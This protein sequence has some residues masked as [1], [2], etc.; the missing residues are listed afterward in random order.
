MNISTIIGILI[1]I[2]LIVASIFLSAVQPGVYVNGPGLLVVV[3]GT[4]AATL[5]SFPMQEL[6]RVTNIIGLI[7]RQEEYSIREDVSEIANA[8]RLRMR[9]DFARIED[10]LDRIDNPFLRTAIQLVADGTPQEEIMSMLNWRVRRLRER[11]QAEARIFHTMAT[12]APAFGMFGTLVGMVNMLY[13]VNGPDLMSTGHN[14]AV[15]LMTTLYGLILSNLI[16]KP[17]GI[18]LERRT[19]GRVM[20]MHMI[21]EGTLLL[22]D[23]RSP[24]FIR[25]T[26]KSF[27]A[28]HEDEL[29]GGREEDDMIKRMPVN[30]SKDGD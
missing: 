16:F 2:G 21:M 30:M 22:A 29:R 6:Q 8:A 12:Y 28:Q 5:V 25:E 1:G 10:Q 15:A 14:M 3:G 4:M 20:V 27:V 11:E 9:G 13:D 19:E 18:K 7:F 26:L 17:I 23:N 24:A